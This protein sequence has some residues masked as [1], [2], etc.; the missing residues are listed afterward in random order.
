MKKIEIFYSVYFLSCGSTSTAST[1]CACS[2]KLLSQRLNLRRYSWLSVEVQ[3]LLVQPGAK[4]LATDVQD[5]W[6]HDCIECRF[7]WLSLKVGIEKSE[8][9]FP[10]TKIRTTVRKEY[11]TFYPVVAQAFVST[12]FPPRFIYLFILFVFCGLL[13]LL[14]SQI[15]KIVTE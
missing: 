9:R 7:Y 12:P 14:V 13:F 11:Y 6:E 4:F 2:Q 8:N 15:H 5:C 1:C 10:V 3:K